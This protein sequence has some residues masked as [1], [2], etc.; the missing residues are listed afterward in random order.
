KQ[1][2]IEP[3]GVD[4]LAIDRRTAS[5]SWSA[6]AVRADGTNLDR[7]QFLAV[8][9]RQADDVF[10]ALAVAH[11]EDSAGGD[12]RR[13]VVLPEPLSLPDEIRS[14]LRPLLQEALFARDGGALRPLPLRPIVG[15]CAVAILLGRS[16]GCQGDEKYR[17][18]EQGMTHDL[19]PEPGGKK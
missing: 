3:Q 6:A 14:L 9:L 5:R 19:S 11:D 7:P 8:L 18:P 13:A 2:A 16:A 1:I 15:T 4:Q 10:L 12:G 17:A